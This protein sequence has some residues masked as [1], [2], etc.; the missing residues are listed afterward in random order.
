MARVF[1]TRRLP[2]DGLALLREHEVVF[3]SLGADEPRALDSAELCAAA[4]QADAIL[5]LLTDKID[6]AVLEAGRGRLAV[7]ANVAVGVDNIDLVTAN[8]LGIK[9]CATPGLAAPYRK[10]HPGYPGRDG[11][12]G[13]ERGGGNPLGSNALQ[14]GLERGVRV[15]DAL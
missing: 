2:G 6:R 3:G 15:I 11:A 7:V 8:R 14:F 1:V 12:P 10:R 4:G 5:C 9:I 13:R